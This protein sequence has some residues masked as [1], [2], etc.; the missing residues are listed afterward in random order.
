MRFGFE[1]TIFKY[2]FLKYYFY[3]VSHIK[4]IKMCLKASK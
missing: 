4:N 3:K 1:T 2:R